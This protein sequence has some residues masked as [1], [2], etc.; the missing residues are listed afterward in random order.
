MRL[1]VVAV[2]AGQPSWVE[3]AF[4]EYAK[5][6]PREMRVELVEVRAEPRGTG[7]PVAALLAAEA[8]RV[9]ASIPRSALRVVLD[10]RGREVDTRALARLMARWR[11]GG[12]DVA[13]LIGGPDGLARDV[14]ESAD[15]ALRLSSLTLPH[16]LARVILAEA[17]YRAASVLGRHPYHRE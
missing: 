1:V 4:D 3:E 11:E 7:K 2:G 14:K 13:F 12:R 9:E 15:I 10:E 6:L 5:R 16:G 8:K 17:L